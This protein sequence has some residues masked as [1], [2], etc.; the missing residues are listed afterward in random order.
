[1]TPGRMLN[2]VAGLSGEQM[3]AVGKLGLWSL[4]KSNI[5]VVLKL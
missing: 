5:D 2:D 4:L 1:M 3:K